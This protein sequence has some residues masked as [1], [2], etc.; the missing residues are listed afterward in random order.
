[1]E[2]RIILNNLETPFWIDSTG[3]L[4]NENNN[5]WLK[6]GMNKGYHFYSVFFKGKQYILYTHRLVAEYF[7]PNP[8]PENFNIVHH[9]DSNKLN[10]N[11]SNLE[12]MSVKEHNN[13]HAQ[14][15]S[16]QKI[17]I[18]NEEINVDELKQFRDSPYYASKDGQIYNLDKNIKMRFEN[19]GNYY[20]VQCQYNLMVSIFKYTELST[21]VSK[22]QSRK[23]KK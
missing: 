4:R 9:K 15:Y 6:G 17:Y 11:L 8:D 2:K 3:R 19:C 13:I 23:G 16:V 18:D 12:W 20:R 1:M 7:L 10:N 5:H 21:N 22:G 14:R